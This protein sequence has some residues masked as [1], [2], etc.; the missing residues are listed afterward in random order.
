MV[1]VREAE[2][3]RSWEGTS[4]A[5]ERRFQGIHE[6]YREFRALNA[7]DSSGSGG[8]TCCITP[9]T[10]PVTLVKRKLR[11]GARD[12]PRSQ[13]PG[14]TFPTS[15]SRARLLQAP[16]PSQLRENRCPKST[17]TAYRGQ[18]QGG[19]GRIT[20]SRLCCCCWLKGTQPRPGCPRSG[21]RAAPQP[22]QASPRLPGDADPEGKGGWS[23]DTAAAGPPQAA[24]KEGGRKRRAGHGGSSSMA[25]ERGN[26]APER[27]E[28]GGERRGRRRSGAVTRC[29]GGSAGSRPGGREAGEGGRTYSHLTP[30][31]AR[32]SSHTLFIN[33]SSRRR[34]LLP[35]ID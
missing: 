21:S 34:R 27:P 8:N 3:L 14:S 9:P 15:P 18:A 25:G 30:P 19:E 2:L 13:T 10:L 16:L 28:A 12:H 26:P 23:G 4:A 24:G 33:S 1:F 5:T 32:R 29:R 22:G 31:A 6:A 11:E 17:C 35:T 20:S 7:P